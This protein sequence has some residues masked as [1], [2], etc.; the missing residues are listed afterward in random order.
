MMI[1][2]LSF[3]NTKNFLMILVVGSYLE[4]GRLTSL[5]H[6]IFN[7]SLTAAIS[8]FVI[9][10]VLYCVCVNSSQDTLDAPTAT[11]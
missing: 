4:F 9:I 5:N 3:C 10:I 7:F 6:L 1:S 2:T 8:W 11:F